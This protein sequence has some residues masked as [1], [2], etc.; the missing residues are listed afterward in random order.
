M[1]KRPALQGILTITLL[2]ALLLVVSACSQAGRVR[3]LSGQY[4]Q[5]H[6]YASLVSLIPELNTFDLKRA[7]VEQ[8]LGQPAYCPTTGICYYITDESVPTLCGEGSQPR[9]ETCI[10]PASGQEVPPLRFTL[11]LVVRYKLATQGYLPDPSDALTG[12]SL[13]PVGE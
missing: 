10:N 4:Q 7:D 9:G 1:N 8:L 13:S 2:A 6:D 11:I 5:Q 12:F 3:R